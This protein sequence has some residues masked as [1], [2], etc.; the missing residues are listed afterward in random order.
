[1]ENTSNSKTQK[2][3]G[4][5]GIVLSGL[6][7]PVILSTLIPLIPPA[8]TP[9]LKTAIGIFAITLLPSILLCAAL[10]AYEKEDARTRS[11]MRKTL[12][13]IENLINER[14]QRQNENSTKNGGR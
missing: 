11:E 7:I 9:Y 1:M 2:T 8:Q 3:T 4:A 14:K 12:D 6:T 10:N 13:R 5:L